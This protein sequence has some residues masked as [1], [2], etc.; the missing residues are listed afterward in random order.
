M[1]IDTLIAFL[2]Q[3]K[4]G[5]HGSRTVAVRMHCDSDVFGINLALCE[6]EHV[7]VEGEPDGVFMLVVNEKPI[8]CQMTDEEIAEATA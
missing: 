4:E 5:T 8:G 7:M 6:W 1:N 2:E 3:I